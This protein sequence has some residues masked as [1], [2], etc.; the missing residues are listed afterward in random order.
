MLD[1]ERPDL[2]Q[3]DPFVKAYIEA[4]EAELERF[5]PNQA[6][7][8][9]IADLEVFE[10]SEPPSSLSLVSV[11]HEGMIKRTSRHLYQRQRRGGMGI[12]DL[13]TSGDDYPSMLCSADESQHLLVFTNQGR[14]FRLPVVKIT[15]TP[16]RSRGIPIRDLLNL[17]RNERPAVVLSDQASG[18]VALVTRRGVVRCL[19]HHLFGEYIRPGTV[20]I[21]TVDSGELA[22]ACWTP[23]DADLFI[24]TREGMA[25]RFS[26]KLVSLKG[27]HAIR[28]AEDDEVVAVT[29]VRPESGV[30]MISADG[31]GTVRSME[32]FAANKSGGGS[33][34]IA[35]KSSHII[36]AI[37]T[38]QAL[39]L[40]AI[41][42][43]GKIIRFRAEEVPPTEGVVQGVVCMS[44]RG[45]EVTAAIKTVPV[46]PVTIMQH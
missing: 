33:G 18:Y 16:V 10:V 36:T 31:K 8:A 34:K 43:Q 44:L 41:S 42:R 30:Y 4:L 21:N 40:F 39:D 45:D 32:G 26:E 12:F 27:D 7:L 15:S 35:M 20:L 6:Q 13:E 2:S 22:S 38:D 25:I 9:Q 1:V 37:S 28:L 5:K 19:R 17:E 29:A 14:V 11:S 46:S 3:V 24:C 23:G